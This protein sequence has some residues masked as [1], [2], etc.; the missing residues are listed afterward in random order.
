MQHSKSHYYPLR[1]AF[2]ITG[3]VASAVVLAAVLYAT[4]AQSTDI[5]SKASDSMRVGKTWQFKKGTD[6]WK[7][8]HG[9]SVSAENGHLV[10]RDESQYL[11]S[12]V[13]N[14]AVNIPAT[15]ENMYMRVR[16]GVTDELK[17]PKTTLG[18]QSSSKAMPFTAQIQ[19]KGMNGLSVGAPVMIQSGQAVKEYLLPIHQPE[20]YANQN[21][22]QEGNASGNKMNE[23][24]NKMRIVEKIRISWDFTGASHEYA[25]QI[26][27]ESIEFVGKT[28][29][30]RPTFVA[31][32][33][34][35]NTPTPW[36]RMTPMLK[37]YQ[38]AGPGQGSN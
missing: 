34:E 18:T 2:I 13:E 5:R 10:V 23:S 24:A 3:I 27:I 22:K 4:S 28:D 20:Q 25:K 16:L 35:G 30:P 17:G 31:L 9:I 19:W 37:K 33:R 12:Y 15:T 14:S 32:P 21:Q 6:G 8:S 26:R 1:N 7:G 36:V 38:G 11:S 29:G